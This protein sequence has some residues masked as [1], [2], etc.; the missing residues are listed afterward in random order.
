MSPTSSSVVDRS[1]QFW[2]RYIAFLEFWK[3]RLSIGGLEEQ[4]YRWAW[5][6]LR[7]GVS[8]LWGAGVG[9]EGTYEGSLRAPIA[10]Q[11]I[12]AT[13]RHNN[14][15]ISSRP[16]SSFLQAC[17]EAGQIRDGTDKKPK[18][19]IIETDGRWRTDAV[20]AIYMNLCLHFSHLFSARECTTCNE[21]GSTRMPCPSCLSNDAWAR[22]HEPARPGLDLVR[23]PDLP[24]PRTASHRR[25]T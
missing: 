11:Y 8:K 16:S 9:R 1:A 21:P 12:I 4:T 5:W 15:R 20:E 3:I 10:K 25:Y 23:G 17:D 14:T 22:P 6:W 2:R 13:K 19:W 18:C 7:W 24:G